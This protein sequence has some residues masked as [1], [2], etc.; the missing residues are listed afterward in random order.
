MRETERMIMLNVI[1]N[2][3][4]DH[5]LSMDHL[6][7]GIG[8]R[9]YGQKDPLIEYKKESFVLFQDM[10]DRIEDETVRFLF[11]LQ[12]ATKGMRP[13]NVPH[14]ELWKR[15]MTRRRPAAR[16]RI[17]GEWHRRRSAGGAEHVPGFHAQYPAQ[18]R[19]GNGRRCNSSAAIQHH[20]TAGDRRGQGRPQRP[21]PL[22]QRKEV[23]K[24]LWRI[25]VIST[26]FLASLN[27]GLLPE[28]FGNYS[29]ESVKPAPLTDRA[30]WD[31]F[32]FDAAERAVYKSGGNQLTAT[33]YRLKDPTGALAAFQ[34]LRPADATMLKPIEHVGHGAASGNASLFQMGNYLLSFEGNRPSP[35]DLKQI[36]V[37]LPK[38]DQSSLPA[39]GT[40]VPARNLV[41][42]SER[43][44]LG[45]GIPSEVRTAD[46]SLHRRLPHGS[47]SP[48]LHASRPKMGNRSWRSSPTPR[49]R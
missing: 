25:S 10:M 45:T 11:F 49:H 14:P 33:A 16:A 41:L 26:I 27:A 2:Q 5:L 19:K 8:L 37:H 31:E 32:G 12:R 20:A 7:E 4:K 23:Q 22:R 15:K 6:K 28:R 1:D 21:L 24:M 48:S 39:L 40:Y 42:N 29:Q 34:W 9:G 44:I 47:G 13:A 46:P 17:G 35:M 18:E 30:V 3:W 36:F 38:F 43:M